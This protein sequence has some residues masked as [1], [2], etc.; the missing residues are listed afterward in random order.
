[1][2]VGRLERQL[3]DAPVQDFGHEKF[4][5][6]RASD[7]VDPAKVAGLLAGLAE[8]A[9]EFAIETE[10]VDAAG[11]GVGGEEDLIGR[12]RDADGPGSAGR[13]GAGALRGTIAD[14][15]TRVGADGEIDRDLAEEFSIG[16]EDLDAAIA[17]VG[18]VDIVVRVD[19]NVVRGVE[20]AGLI[21][22]LAPGFEPDTVFVGLG[23]AGIDV[24][25]ADVGVAG[26]VPGHVGDLAEKSVNGRERRLGML[27][28]LGAFVGGFLLAA[29]DHHDAAL[30]IE[31]D[32]HVGA[33]VGDPDVVFFIDA[34]GM[35]EGPG[36][37]V[38]A[39]FAEKFSVGGEFEELRGGGSVGWP[40]GV[41][42]GE[43]EDVAFGVDRDAYGFA[44]VEVG[45]QLEEVEDG[46]VADFGDG[47]LLR[48][49]RVGDE[50][51]KREKRESHGFASES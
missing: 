20:L 17:A 18:D 8:P 14:G 30:R 41:A 48:G 24:A 40:G 15:G 33:F 21:A 31:L 25:V 38:V 36:V 43:D 35:R 49:K 10:F 29:E 50:E 27:E 23:D 11:E 51:K 22:G 7:F 45:G 34:N 6:G 4:V 2:S 46:A 19:A 47:G 13:H 16:V 44:E 1:V 9:E 12:R 5:L 42:A 37:E 32:D 26:G 28:R 3:L 39:D